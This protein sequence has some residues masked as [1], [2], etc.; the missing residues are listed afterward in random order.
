MIH[1]HTDLRKEVYLRNVGPVELQ[2]IRY[3]EEVSRIS[4]GCLDYDPD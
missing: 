3:V 1:D 4:S 2:Y